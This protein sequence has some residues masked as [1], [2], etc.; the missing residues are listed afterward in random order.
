MV[1]R[2]SITTSHLIS[3]KHNVRSNEAKWPHKS[4]WIKSHF[5]LSQPNQACDTI[6]SIRIWCSTTFSLTVWRN[7]AKWRFRQFF[8]PLF[9][10]HLASF[11]RTSCFKKYQCQNVWLTFHW[12]MSWRRV[13]SKRWNTWAST[14]WHTYSKRRRNPKTRK[15][16]F[17][18]SIPHN[19]WPKGNGDPF[20]EHIHC[21]WSSDD[22]G[23]VW[24]VSTQNSSGFRLAW[25]AST[26]PNP[27]WRLDFL[28]LF[29]VQR[30]IQWY[31]LQR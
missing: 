1:I 17:G 8:Y 12:K 7:S 20:W 22:I 6:F 4:G 19:C 13:T 30:Q 10:G 25:N 24:Y 9:C 26:L 15:R 27:C 18:Y 16:T 31:L 28:K 29:G 2:Q 11:F 21:T 5:W 3:L 23:Q 14:T